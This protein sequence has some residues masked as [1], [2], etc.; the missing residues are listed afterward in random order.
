MDMIS[1]AI[2]NMY[3][4]KLRTFLT[5]AGVII[6]IAA[7]VSMLSFGAGMQENVT[8]E[9]NQLGLFN[10]MIVYKKSDRDTDDRRHGRNDE[11]EETVQTDTTEIAALDTTSDSTTASIPDSTVI[12]PL[13]DEAIKLLSEIPGVNLVYPNASYSVKVTLDDTT[14][15]TNAQMIPLQALNTKLFSQIVAGENLQS[16]STREV[17]ITKRLLD[18]LE[19]DSAETMIGK[20]LI[21]TAEASVLDSGLVHII[22]SENFDIRDHLDSLHF[23]S[24]FNADYRTRVLRREAND[25]VSRFFDGYMNAKMAVSDT[26]TI[27]GVLDAAH[28][29][30]ISTK[31]IIIPTVTGQ[32]FSAV[33]AGSDPLDMFGML[34]SGQFNLFEEK[35]PSREYAKLT[36]DIDPN[37]MHTSISDSVKAL[38]YRP[39]SYA[40]QFEEIQKVFMYFN[41]GLGVIGLIALI[42]ASLGIVNTMVMTIMER[43]REIGVLKSLGADEMYIRGLFLMESSLIGAF[44][45]AG[46]IFVGW[47]ISRIVSFTAKQFM[48]NEGVDPIELFSVPWWLILIAFSIGLIVAILAG[49]FPSSRAAKIDPV[50]ALRND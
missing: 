23:D 36:M 16:D 32:K 43:R 18:I 50:T 34:Q 21:V 22:R 47:L 19:V 5:V 25:A 15:S 27:V 17:L 29:R 38:G 49:Y 37:I 4:M 48:I 6:A 3:R 8:A 44:G 1:I 12:K 7:F 10:T 42:T 9:F 26:L 2:G 31:E 13:D 28:G 41:M 46:G 45:A 14:I 24:L 35:Q 11:S 39:F 20:Q 33:G 30:R 40:E